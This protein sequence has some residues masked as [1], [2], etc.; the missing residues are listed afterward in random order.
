MGKTSG[1]TVLVTVRLPKEALE[2]MDQL[3]K[4]GVF[5]ESRSE[6]IRTAIRLRFRE[7]DSSPRRPA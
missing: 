7:S 1:P 3:R 2:R 4:R 6:Y 5:P